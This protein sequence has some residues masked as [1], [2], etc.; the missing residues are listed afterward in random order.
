MLFFYVSLYFVFSYLLYNGFLITFMSQDQSVLF[1]TTTEVSH[2]NS[3]SRHTTFR[4]TYVTL[5]VLLVCEV[6]DSVVSILLLLVYFSLFILNTLFPTAP[7]RSSV[8]RIRPY[9][10]VDLVTIIRCNSGLFSV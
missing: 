4:S 3:G 9:Q 2:Y 1:L 10:T 6:C 7:L 8:H 5:D